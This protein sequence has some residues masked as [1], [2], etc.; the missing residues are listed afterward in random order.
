MTKDGLFESCEKEDVLFDTS[1]QL[2]LQERSQSGPSL[3]SLCCSKILSDL[4]K[5]DEEYLAYVFH[6]EIC[7]RRRMSGFHVSSLRRRLFQQWKSFVEDRKVLR[8]RSDGGLKS[9]VDF[10]QRVTPGEKESVLPLLVQ[11]RREI[12]DVRI[13]KKEIRTE[14]TSLFDAEEE[15]DL[16]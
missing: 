6:D 10:L 15:E 7:F 4:R 5:S 1:S 11:A 3:S 2:V 12:E 16:E 14:K 13:R 8:L 9:L